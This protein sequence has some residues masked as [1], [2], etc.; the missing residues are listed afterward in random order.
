MD[1]FTFLFGNI[2]F[3][4]LIRDGPWAYCQIS[5]GPDMS[6]PQLFSE[7]G[8]F[9]KQHSWTGPLQPLHNFTDGL[10]RMVRNEDV[11]MVACYLTR[12]NLQIMLHSNLAYQV[13][14]TNGYWPREYFLAIL[15][16]PH[17]VNLKIVFRVRAYSVP[18]HT[19]ILHEI[20]LRLK[21]RGFHHPRRGH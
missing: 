15:R 7:V 12:H 8:E 19:T 14:H 21:A 18:S 11:N 6:P 10:M 4:H 5:S 9:L 1:G 20:F 3:D 13:A 17:Q 16:Y 2:L